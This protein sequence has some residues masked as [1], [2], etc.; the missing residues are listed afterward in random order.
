MHV[1]IFDVSGGRVLLG[2]IQVHLRPQELE[3]RK[4]DERS[5]TSKK[6]KKNRQKKNEILMKCHSSTTRTAP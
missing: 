6:E 1:F 3:A 5:T 2:G 4:E